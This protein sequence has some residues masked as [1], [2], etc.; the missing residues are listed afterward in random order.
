MNIGARVVLKH[1]PHGQPGIV[2]RIERNR[3]SRV[4][5]LR[6]KLR[7]SPRRFHYKNRYSLPRTKR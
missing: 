6:R 1:C 3:A 2:V 4:V 7:L 5:A